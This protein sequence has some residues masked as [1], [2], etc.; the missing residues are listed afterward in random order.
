MGVT[1]EN[2]AAEHQITRE[3]QDA[4]ALESQ[5]RA[6]RAIAE[7][8]I[9]QQ[10]VPVEVKVK[11]DMVVVRHRRASQGHHAGGAGGAATVF[12]KDGTVTAGNASG[13]N[14]GAAAIVLAR[15]TPPRPPG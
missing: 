2:V 13:I 12:K 1:A 14:D 5:K 15:A 9:Q 4:F 6:A 10:I 11:R 7:G 8:R 3:D